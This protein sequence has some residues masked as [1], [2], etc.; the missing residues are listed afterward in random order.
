VE[1]AVDVLQVVVLEQRRQRVE[2]Q[3]HP[4]FLFVPPLE[5]L[6][7]EHP[8]AREVAR[9]REVLHVDVVADVLVGH[10]AG[11]RVTGRN[12]R[13]GRRALAHAFVPPGDPLRRRLRKAH[14]EHRPAGVGRQQVLAAGVDGSL[15]RRA[16]QQHVRRALQR[17]ERVRPVHSRDS[18]PPFKYARP[19]TARRVAN[20]ARLEI[21]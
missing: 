14:G 15:D 21:R 16:Q 2:A 3:R 11:E 9:A 20:R 12:D 6:A 1:E 17:G 7:D 8:Q 5:V 10:R 19:G 4:P 18:P 13:R